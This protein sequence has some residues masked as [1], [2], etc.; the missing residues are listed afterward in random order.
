MYV[1]KEAN[2]DEVA[3]DLRNQAPTVVLVCCCDGEVAMLMQTALS[4]AAVDNKT[5]GEWEKGRDTGAH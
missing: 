5:H 1:G 2:I 3:V 4:K